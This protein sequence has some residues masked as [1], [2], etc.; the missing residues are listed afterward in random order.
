MTSYNPMRLQNYRPGYDK[1][2]F[3]CGEYEKQRLLDYLSTFVQQLFSSV[4]F[5]AS[6]DCLML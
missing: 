5:E 6:V 1:L 4:W 3:A 2:V